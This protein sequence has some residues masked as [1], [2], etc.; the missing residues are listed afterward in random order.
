[1]PLLCKN[2]TDAMVVDIIIAAS[3]SVK[4]PWSQILLKSSPPVA[5]LISK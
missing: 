4:V 3:L 1:M 2:A 5:L